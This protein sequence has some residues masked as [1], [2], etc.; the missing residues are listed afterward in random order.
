MEQF[1]LVENVDLILLFSSHPRILFSILLR[2]LG[3]TLQSQVFYL[4]T[5]P[6]KSLP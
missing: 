5:S 1:W 6:S 3:L 2:S 4:D